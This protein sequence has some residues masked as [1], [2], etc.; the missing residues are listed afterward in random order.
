LVDLQTEPGDNYMIEP[1]MSKPF[2]YTKD[3]KIYTV[4]L[5]EVGEHVI[6]ISVYKHLGIWLCVPFQVIESPSK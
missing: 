6:S 5:D 3:W 1:W 2:Y 4:S